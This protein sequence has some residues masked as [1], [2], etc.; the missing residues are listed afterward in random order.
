MNQNQ[1]F[2][3]LY[4]AG[5]E[6]IMVTQ[7]DDNEAAAGAYDGKAFIVNADVHYFFAGSTL[8][9]YNS[10]GAGVYQSGM[11]HVH[12]VATNTLTLSC[13]KFAAENIQNTS[14]LYPGILFDVDWELKQVEL[15]LA[16]AV[17][18]S[19][20]FIIVLDA[21]KGTYWDTTYY[22]K[23]MAGVTDIIWVPESGPIAISKKDL[24]HFTWTNSES[25]NWGLKVWY[26]RVA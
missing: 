6:N 7:M 23:A 18:A 11:R 13:D 8:Y 19:E 21:N 25:I 17:T 9:W 2:E 1:P 15:H 4:M 12:A 26:R 24:L 3:C 14:Y 20:D 16:S 22:T 5:A 10:D